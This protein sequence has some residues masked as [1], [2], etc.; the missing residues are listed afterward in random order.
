MKLLY[1]GE[2]QDKEAKEENG[3]FVEKILKR[4]YKKDKF[5]AE[6]RLIE[7]EG[8]KDKLFSILLFPYLAL[9]IHTKAKILRKQCLQ[10]STQ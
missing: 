9:Y 2:W 10:I 6:F 4:S 5:R 1:I 3:N 7:Y 8:M